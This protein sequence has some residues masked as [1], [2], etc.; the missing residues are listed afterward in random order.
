MDPLHPE[1]CPQKEVEPGTTEAHHRASLTVL[2]KPSKLYGKTVGATGAN[3]PEEGWGL[4]CWLTRES[5]T[6]DHW[7]YIPVAHKELDKACKV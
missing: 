6:P 2:T 4:W 5:P 1:L 7:E 3:G